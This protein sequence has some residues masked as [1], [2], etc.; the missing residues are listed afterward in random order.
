MKKI[1]FFI[2]T[3]YS[4]NFIKNPCNTLFFLISFV[5]F[6]YNITFA[7]VDL[8]IDLSYLVFGNEAIHITTK[9]V[10]TADCEFIEGCIL[11]TGTRKL[12][13][14][15]TRSKN[16]GSSNL[17]IGNP[18]NPQISGLTFT[19][20]TCTSHSNDPDH[21]HFDYAKYELYDVTCNT[22][23]AVN[24]AGF[25]I[26]NSGSISG[27]GGCGDRWT[28]CNPHIGGFNC[29]CQGIGAGC[30][31]DYCSDIACQL[32]DITNVP[33]G[34]YFFKAT[35]NYLQTLP[36]SNYSN[37]TAYVL[38]EIQ[39]N[40]V[41]VIYAAHTIPHDLNINCTVLSLIHEGFFVFPP[42]PFTR[43]ARNDL[44][45][46]CN[47]TSNGQPV[48][49]I[50]GNS[51]RMTD[52]FRS[53]DNFRAYTLDPCLI[54]LRVAGNDS[55]F[56]N[57]DAD[58]DIIQD[59]TKDNTINNEMFYQNDGIH[60]YPNPSRGIFN[61]SLKFEQEKKTK[62]VVYN[63]FGKEIYVV[64]EAPILQKN[65][66][67]NLSSQPNGV[68]IVRLITDDEVINKKIILSK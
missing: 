54:N 39:G 21:K 49:L 38:I 7:G 23:V 30:Y 26:E 15:G 1:F 36:E 37:N 10:T 12:L 6:N 50:A 25:C 14:F 32:I 31:D 4:K 19:D 66:Q 41:E 63:I 33:D 51:I 20:P 68:Y 59:Q 17:V 61:L 57:E 13:R 40:N 45:V 22:V 65:Y 34:K 8:E 16:I 46:N 44:T 58:P 29:G 3:G 9:N 35:I 11:G 28:I 27:G 67:I 64:S 56:F 47:I 42:R 18:N 60:L 55:L 24:K 62:I 2:S 52:G 43:L 53:G 48:T 5:C